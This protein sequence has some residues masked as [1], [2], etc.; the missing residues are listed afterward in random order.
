MTNSWLWLVGIVCVWPIS[1]SLRFGFEVT[2]RQLLLACFFRSRSV[3]LVFKTKLFRQ[4][5]FRLCIIMV[6]IIKS[7]TVNR[8]LEC[9]TR[10][11]VKWLEVTCGLAIFSKRFT[12]FFFVHVFRRF[13]EISAF[14]TDFNYFLKWFWTEI[15]RFCLVLEHCSQMRWINMFCLFYNLVPDLL[16]CEQSED[17]LFWDIT[18]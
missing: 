9:S 18:A 1:R 11:L 2:N 17:N 8:F 15:K 12:S 16:K 6:S 13:Y 4:T 7:I 10:F 3:V 5:L 14:L